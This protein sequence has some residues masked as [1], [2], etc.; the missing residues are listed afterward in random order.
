[1]IPLAWRRSSP[2]MGQHALLICNILEIVTIGQWFGLVERENLA[3]KTHLA[4]RSSSITSQ[5][6]SRSGH[7]YPW[8]E[9]EYGLPYKLFE[10][11][12]VL[13]SK[14]ENGGRKRA[15]TTRATWLQKNGW[16]DAEY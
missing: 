5:N 12:H 14:S 11:S 3:D 1:M 16:K 9:D 13:G 10:L 7:G 2:K 15:I 4:H 8:S 6:M